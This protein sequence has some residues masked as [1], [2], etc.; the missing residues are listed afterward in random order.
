ML[1]KDAKKRP[2]PSDLLNQKL[3]AVDP[4]DAATTTADGDSV[5]MNKVHKSI[6]PRC[7]TSIKGYGGLTSPPL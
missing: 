5:Q 1:D 4:K 7:L 6:D 2:S 3:F